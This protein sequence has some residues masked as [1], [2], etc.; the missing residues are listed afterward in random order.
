MEQHVDRRPVPVDQRAVDDF[1]KI[2]RAAD[3]GAQCD[4]APGGLNHRAVPGP[5][6]RHEGGAELLLAGQLVC[7]VLL[8]GA[9]A[10]CRS[11]ADVHVAD[12]Q[13]AHQPDGQRAPVTANGDRRRAGKAKCGSPLV[14]RGGG[15]L[16]RCV[17]HQASFSIAVRL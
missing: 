1:D 13:Q 15:R 5:P 10:G 2:L 4:D 9:L 12:E 7:D 11:K 3:R 14:Q 17:H 6:D 8:A 16:D